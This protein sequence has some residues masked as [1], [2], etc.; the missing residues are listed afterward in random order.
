[1]SEHNNTEKAIMDAAERIFL[2]KG[3]VLA[4]TTRIAQEAGVTHAMLHYYFRTKEQIFMKVLDKNL[5]ELL[6]SLHAVMKFDAP[7]WDSVKD[8][9]L[10]FFDYL[11]EHR[12]L[13]NML[14]DVIRQSPKLIEKYR[15]SMM[16]ILNGVFVNHQMLLNKEIE[17]GR[18]ND[19][20][21]GQLLYDTIM[22]SASTFMI[23]P[24]MKNVAGLEGAEIEKFIAGRREEIITTMR[25]RLYG[26][27]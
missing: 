10:L 27:L 12:Q 9:M 26:K 18:I 19:I 1:M 11:N 3:Y 6:D 4:T 16:R 7:F 23:V 5:Y 8:G 22:M 25:Y 2:E 20:D 21:F 17:E 14:F 24:V 15:E 13:A